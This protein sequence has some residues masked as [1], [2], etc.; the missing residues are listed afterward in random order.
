[1]LELTALSVGC[2]ARHLVPVEQQGRGDQFEAWEA[3]FLVGFTQG[4]RFWRGI[5]SF[6]VAAGLE[7]SPNTGVQGQQHA[8]GRGV[9][10]E[11]ACGD[12]PCSAVADHCVRMRAQMFQKLN[13]KAFLAGIWCRPRPHDL[14]Y[15]TMQSGFILGSHAHHVMT[16]RGVR[17]INMTAEVSSGIGKIIE[18]RLLR[19]ECAR[20]SE[21]F[22]IGQQI[23]VLPKRVATCQITFGSQQ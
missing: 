17:R 16:H 15:L 19:Q 3:T 20:I 12:V 14:A 4:R 21:I 11:G 9:H 5:R 7:P 13:A 8:F 10:D 2:F 23:R 18:V 22:V 1:M 6:H